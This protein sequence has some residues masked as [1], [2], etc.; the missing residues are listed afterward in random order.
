MIPVP[1]HLSQ[2]IDLD[3]PENSVC[4]VDDILSQ[5]MDDYKSRWN[6]KSN[7]LFGKRFVDHFVRTTLHV[8]KGDQTKNYSICNLITGLRYPVSRESDCGYKLISSSH[9]EF[10]RLLIV[11][12]LEMIGF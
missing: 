4:Q 9:S 10:C 5:R 2:R 3:R 12:P 8:S 11:K 1:T 6:I 7:I